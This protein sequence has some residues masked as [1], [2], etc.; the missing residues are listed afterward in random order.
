MLK[1]AQVAAA[2]PGPDSAKRI[3]QHHF[4]TG[5]EEVVAGKRVMQ[6]SLFTG[7]EH[8]ASAALATRNFAARDARL[9]VYAFAAAGA[10]LLVAVIALAVALLT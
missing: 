4:Q 10:S 5:I 3:H 2:E 1:A 9:V 8:A 7:Q 6:Q